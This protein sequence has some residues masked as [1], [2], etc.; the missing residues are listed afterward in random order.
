MCPAV[1][2]RAS[3]AVLLSSVPIFVVYVVV[4]A[5]AP[6]TS[7]TSAEVSSAAVILFVSVLSTTAVVSSVV[8]FGSIVSSVTIASCVSSTPLAVILVGVKERLYVLYLIKHRLHH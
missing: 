5:V 4:T 7:I 8:S 2:T 6:S 3:G 1:T